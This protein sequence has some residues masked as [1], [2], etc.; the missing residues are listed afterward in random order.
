MVIKL[1]TAVSLGSAKQF[2]R[3]RKEG[4]DLRIADKSSHCIVLDWTFCV[5]NWTSAD[6]RDDPFL[7]LHL[8]LLGNLCLKIKD[9]E[10][11]LGIEKSLGTAKWKF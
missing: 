7:A 6:A 9:R 2:H 10:L 5:E 1:G 8:I 4:A 3:D 11:S